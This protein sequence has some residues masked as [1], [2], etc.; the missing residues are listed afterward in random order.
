MQAQM[1]Q[2]NERFEFLVAS[3]GEHKKKDPPVYEGKY[4]E[5][6]ELWIFATE[7]YY[8]NKRHIME[9]DS[10]DFVTL[11]SSNLGKSVLNWYRAFITDCERMS[12]HQTWS[13]FKRQLRTRFR[14]KDFEYDL[15]ERMFHLKQK[16]TIHEY[17]S[18]FQ[19][20]LS[21]TELEISELEKRFFFQNGLR[22]ETA[23]KI[24]EE[25]PSTLQDAME[26]A[27]NFEFAHYS[28][29]PPRIPSKSS[30]SP[31]ESGK[32]SI[33]PTSQK[34]KRFE[35]KKN[36]ND[37]WTKTA[38]CNNCG[39]VGHISPQCTAPK[40]KEANR[41]ISGA[42]YA[43]LEAEAH[44]YKETGQERSVTI[45]IDNGCSLNGV[46]EEL[47]KTLGLDVTEGELMQ[48]DLGYDQ[49]V[50][51]PRRTVEMNLQLPGFPL[52]SGT[53]QV[54]PVPENKDVILGMMWLREQN[55]D[56]DWSTGQVTPRIKMEDEQDAQLRLPKQRPARRVA[57]QR[58]SRIDQSREI[59]NHYRQHGH[60]GQYG[61]T[62]LISAQQFLRMLRHDKDIEA[63][64]VINP[65]DS[66]K[67]ERFKSQGWEALKDNPAYDI[68]RKYA[69]TVFRTELPNETPPVRE[70]IEHEILLQPGTT[71][72][73]VKQWRQ[74]PDQ[75]ITIQDWT[76]E[77]VQ[78]GIIRPS[79]SAFSAPTFCVKKPV[80][81]RIVHDYR[82]LN[83][84]TILPAIPMPRKEDTF[85]AMAGSHW[86]SCMDLLWGY[87]QVK[88]LV[89]PEHL[90][91]FYRKSLGT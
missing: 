51:R 32:R 24:K 77:M 68:L 47:V 25:S 31:A 17:V 75:R 2:A 40:R 78:A 80:G 29:K 88:L 9:A 74:S 41:Y 14:P 18:K 52:T 46:S 5:D 65:H 49:V 38:T 70:G 7:Q 71:P 37:D 33:K 73:S 45:F 11:I 34:P 1:Q 20:L 48:V 60:K 83:L 89:V 19:D 86:F 13:L 28:G 81:W 10:S 22:E 12:V 67:A 84:A 4:G 26:I 35:K 36:K 23:K 50:H 56:I 57:G 55:P 39:K 54:M 8:A 66:E 72:I 82:Q 6:I 58:R 79:T 69:D 43:I 30:Q 15:R 3:R 85:D 62:R 27:S 64:F 59:F 90:T 44:A 76:K 87:Y 63:I 61:K 53:F 42:L 21:Q 91:V 16:E